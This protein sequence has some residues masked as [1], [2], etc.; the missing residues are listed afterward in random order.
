[1]KALRASVLM[2]VGGALVASGY[3]LQVVGL[4]TVVLGAAA[5]QTQK[6]GSPRN[7]PL[8]P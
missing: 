8:E 6:A 5:V 7:R 3:A 2:L 4:A 1:M